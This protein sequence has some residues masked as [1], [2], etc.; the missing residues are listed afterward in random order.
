[1]AYTLLYVIYNQEA[2]HSFSVY[3]KC[4]TEKLSEMWKYSKE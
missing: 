4:V 1:M 3:L 2:I